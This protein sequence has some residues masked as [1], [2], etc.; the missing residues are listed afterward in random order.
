MISHTFPATQ[1]PGISWIGPG[2]FNSNQNTVKV[3]RGGYYILNLQTANNCAYT[4]SIFVFQDTVKPN[5]IVAGDTINCNKRIITLKAQTASAS[6]LIEWTAPSGQKQTIRDLSAEGGRFSV[7]VTATNFCTQ[8]AILDVPVDTMKPVIQIANDTISCLNLQADLLVKLQNLQDKVRWTG[9]GG[10]TSNLPLEKTSVPGLYQLIVTSG[11]G[12]A[13]LGFVKY[14]CRHDT[15]SDYCKCGRINCKNLESTLNV[16][17]DL[18]GN[19]ISWTDAQGK[20]FPIRPCT[21]FPP[22]EFIK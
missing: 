15:P 14:F 22:Q 11:N 16:F 17:G 18:S 20:I 13:T 10:F 3:N 7:R 12:C 2:S 9:P 8:D 19:R 4:D 6:S 5:L 21:K 1:N